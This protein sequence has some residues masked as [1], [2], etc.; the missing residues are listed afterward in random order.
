MH[1][2]Q[3]AQYFQKP[4]DPVALKCP[5]YFDIVKKPMSLD[6]ISNRLGNSHG[7]NRKYTKVQDFVNDVRQVHAH[8]PLLSSMSA[9]FTHRQLWLFSCL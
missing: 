3:D 2:Q 9:L 5:D 6:I 8:P 1:G 4:V 7:H